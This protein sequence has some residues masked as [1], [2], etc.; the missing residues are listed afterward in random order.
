MSAYRPIA[1]SSCR[2]IV[3]LLCRHI[4]IWSYRPPL[5]LFRLVFFFAYA[6]ILSLPFLFHASSSFLHVYASGLSY[7]R[8]R[9]T[10]L[11]PCPVR[12]DRITPLLRNP[13]CIMVTDARCVCLYTICLSWLATL[14]AVVLL[15]STTLVCC[16]RCGLL[17]HC[18]VTVAVLGT[19]VVS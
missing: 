11:L 12:V 17:C 1:M 2:Y 18:H 16:D 7:G 13:G 15:S 14:Y 19:L 8:N 9:E 6:C 10:L 3:L 4:A 5:C